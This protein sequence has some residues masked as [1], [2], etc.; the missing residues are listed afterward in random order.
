MQTN[1][2]SNDNDN[3]LDIEGVDDGDNFGLSDDVKALMTP[4]E[5][6]AFEATTDEDAAL[7]SV[8]ASLENDDVGNQA[9]SG[10]GDGL[11]QQAAVAG[12]ADSEVEPVITVEPVANLEEELTKLKAERETIRTDQEAKE[13]A[14]KERY[15]TA[16]IDEAE[17]KKALKAIRAQADESIDQIA[18]KMQTMSVQ[19]KTFEQQQLASQEFYKNRWLKESTAF[20]AEA[21]SQ[22]I[23]YTDASKPLLATAFNAEIARLNKAE[24][25]LTDRQLLEKAH[26]AVCEQ[27]GLAKAD[28]AI[29]KAK[30]TIPPNLGSIPAA[31]TMKPMPVNADPRLSAKFAKADTSKGVE[32]ERAVAS[33][34]E[35]ELFEWLRSE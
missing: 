24:P 1:Q 29:Q 23:D 28:I 2:E 33:M 19:A 12:A 14:L 17:Y 6:A 32:Q 31:M 11:Q 8:V 18:D 35:E 5:L 10:E 20:V 16:E 25:Q 30:K 7:G 15:E 13:D 27:L 21:K 34:N 3:N 9:K 4:A 26:K 22:G